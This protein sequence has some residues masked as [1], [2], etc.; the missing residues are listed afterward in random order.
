[1][2]T[3]L[4]FY[5]PYGRLGNRL[6]R[7]SHLASWCWENGLTLWDPTLSDYPFLFP[8]FQGDPLF[9][10]NI[11][12]NRINLIL[13]IR[14][15]LRFIIVK[16]ASYSL[17]PQLNCDI[18]VGRFFDLSGD[19]GKSWL[20]SNNKYPL[21]GINGFWYTSGE[22]RNK[23]HDRLVRIFSPSLKTLNQIEQKLSFAD[24]E[25]ILIGIHV[26][27]TDYRTFLNGEGYYEWNE[28]RDLM[29]MLVKK[30]GLNKVQFLVCCDELIPT[31]F[32]NGLPI[33]NGLGSINDI[34]ALSY[35]DLI[36]GPRSTFSNWAAYIGNSSLI[37]L[38]G[39]PLWK[40]NQSEA[41]ERCLG[42]LST[43]RKIRNPF[44]N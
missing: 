7:Y 21:V 26:R 29:F 6:L 2:R 10:N 1:M 34:F 40:K 14:K 16:M 37:E 12:S 3:V 32:D 23:Y 35:C 24:P 5:K 31:D 33:L 42:S 36:I 17:L 20:N 15:I 44:L 43:N 4:F 39:H 38:W 9:S 11:Q 18:R 28:Y 22:L 27:R 25:K 13:K 8:A 41:L 30:I 19:E